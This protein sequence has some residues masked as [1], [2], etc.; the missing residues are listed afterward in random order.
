MT[1]KSYAIHITRDMRGHFA[2]VQMTLTKGQ[3]TC[4]VG[5]S[6]CGKTT[7]L[8]LLTG[9]DSSES[10]LDFKASDVAY[11]RQLPNLLPWLNVLDNMCLAQKLNP[12]SPCQLQEARALLVRVKLAHIADS[13]P[14]NLSVG[15]QQRVCLLRTFLQKKS[16]VLLDE[17][18][19]AL[20]H[21]TRLDLQT[22]LVELAQ[23][24]AVLLVTHDWLDVMRLAQK[25]Y[26]IQGYPAT[27]HALPMALPDSKLPRAIDYDHLSSIFSKGA[28]SC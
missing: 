19:S 7:L 1:K 6:G 28:A 11:M 27:I 14:K 18:F 8:R 9:L 16:I 13:Y 21:D 17:P 10:R 2:P 20:D 24:S 12:K 22:L 23:E 15:M 5:E 3:I 25:V 4:L 26:S